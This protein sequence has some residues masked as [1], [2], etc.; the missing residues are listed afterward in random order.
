[1]DNEAGQSVGAVRPYL[2]DLESANGTVLNKELVPSKR[3]VELRT[4]DVLRFGESERE[5]VLL[6]PPAGK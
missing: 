4:E 6:L 1:M 5:Y 2:I 3:Y